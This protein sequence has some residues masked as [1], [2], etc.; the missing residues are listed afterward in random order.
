MAKNPL[1]STRQTVPTGPHPVMGHAQMW[2]HVNNMAPD[3]QANNAAA[4][5]YGL[6][7]VGALAGNPKVTRRDVIKAAADAAG[8]GKIPPSQAV[9]MISQMPE[10][11]DKL[12]PWLKGMYSTYLTA[13]VHLKAAMMP[14]PQPQ[15]P[16]AP[17]AATA[18][19]PQQ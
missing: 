9:Q 7:I 1:S 11:P 19:V 12:Q 17:Q 2:Q 10:D 6:P 15:Q 13:L 18:G 3:E 16:A 14:D 5:S 8:A 4:I